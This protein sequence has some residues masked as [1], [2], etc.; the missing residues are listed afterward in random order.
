[1]T[2]ARLEGGKEGSEC[3]VVYRDGLKHWKR[4]GKGFSTSEPPEGISPP[5]NLTLT[6]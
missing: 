6:L 4:Q 1:M 2:E 3:Q 5:G